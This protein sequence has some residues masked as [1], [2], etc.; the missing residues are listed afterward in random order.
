VSSTSRRATRLVLAGLALDERGGLAE[1]LG[2]A[3]A[4][5]GDGDFCRI[6]EARKFDF[7]VEPRA[8]QN[9]SS[10]N[11][12]D[13]LGGGGRSREQRRNKSRRSEDCAHVMTSN[14]VG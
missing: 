4:V 3:F 6:G 2:I 10:I 14:S 9:I 13:R 8:G 7:E 11:R 12:I 1:N 5:Q